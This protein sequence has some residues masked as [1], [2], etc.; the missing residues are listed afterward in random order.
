L[1]DG[2]LVLAQFE[3][4]LKVLLLNLLEL[5]H[6]VQ[7]MTVDLLVK[8]PLQ[9]V[10]LDRQVFDIWSVGMLTTLIRVAARFNLTDA[11]KR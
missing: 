6:L 1:R 2:E 9:L 3:G 8:V 5:V 11:F 4:L 7:V 10:L